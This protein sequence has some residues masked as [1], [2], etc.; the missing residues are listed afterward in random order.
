MAEVVFSGATAD[1]GIQGTLFRGIKFWVSQKVPQRAR[2]IND[3]KVNGGEVVP[4]E[5]QADVKIVDHARKEALPGTHSYTFIEKSI[6][7]GDLEDLEVHRVGASGGTVRSVSSTVQPAKRTR[8][9]Y[10]ETDDCILWDWVQGNPQKGGGTDGNEIYKQL[11]LKHPRHTWQSWRD[12]YIK[13]L[14]GKPRPFSRPQNAPPTPPSDTRVT[15]QPSK[16]SD[17]PSDTKEA[18]QNEF[19]EEEAVILMTFG[20]DIIKILPERVEQAWEAWTNGVDEERRHSAP[21]WRAFWEERVLPKYLG[22]KENKEKGSAAEQAARSKPATSTRSANNINSSQCTFAS[23]TRKPSDIKDTPKSPPYHP[24]S[25]SMQLTGHSTAAQPTDNTQASTEVRNPPARGLPSRSTPRKMNHWAEG[26]ESKRKHA[27]LEE[28]V[29]SSSPPD[30]A[31]SPKR[32]RQ[33]GLR[34][35]LEIASTP[36]SSPAA[37][38]KRRSSPIFTDVND[39]S[40]EASDSEGYGNEDYGPFGQEPSDTLSEPDPAIQ[41]TQA[42]LEADTQPIDLGVPSPDGGWDEE[43][44]EGDSAVESENE[45]HTQ[46]I[47]TDKLPPEGGWADDNSE[48]EAS[49]SE[50]GSISTITE[51]YDPRPEVP[52]TQ[53]ILQTQ[54]QIL[55]L[56]VPDPDESWEDLI[57]SSP[58]PMP[59]SQS[60]RSEDPETE[61]QWRASS[62]N[63]DIEAQTDAWIDSHV[64]EGFLEGQVE[65]AL[66]ATSMD[67][68][69]AEE[70]LKHLAR[71]GEI[72]KNRRGVWT[73]IDDRAIRSTDA[74]EIHRLEEKH[75]A[76]CLDARW[77]FLSF[78][79]E[80]Q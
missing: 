60:H 36:Q 30:T 78:M 70:A 15:A 69:L 12:R 47:G 22:E 57:P 68:N 59:G 48:H 18:S 53:A 79:D 44:L 28:E 16:D 24:N 49:G 58:P 43:E 62:Q 35:P 38:A 56:T 63:P 74:R 42:I 40:E 19:S 61:D 9:R 65:L 11:E 7:N 52:E 50:S 29:A 54:T 66:H 46:S 21:Q 13:C 20:E 27:V 45:L 1:A 71:T 34:L 23:A 80:V 73:E 37:V 64:A 39:N 25:P 41:E 51:I 55:D 67:T 31:L 76:D 17:A 6:S 4:L 75:G 14:K 5:K 33:N 8:N 77:D 3:V 32:R 72:P 10:T 26:K 2:F